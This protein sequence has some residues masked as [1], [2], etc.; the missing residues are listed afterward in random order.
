MLADA[1]EVPTVDDDILKN[2]RCLRDTGEYCKVPK[3]RLTPFVQPLPIPPDADAA[4]RV[5]FLQP[6]VD[7]SDNCK[8][9][10]P[11]ASDPND[12][13]NLYSGEPGANRPPD[14]AL[15]RYAEFRP[16]KRY[17]MFVRP[18]QHLFH[19][20]LMQPSTIWGYG[21]RRGQTF[22]PGPTFRERYGQP[23]VVR[24]HNNL[25]AAYPGNDGF[26]IPQISTHLHNFHSAPESDGGPL[27]FFDTGN[28]MDHHYSLYPAGGDPREVLGQL[29]YHDHRPDFTSQNVYKGLAGNFLA[30]D[31]RDS[32]DERDPHPRA[33][34][35][36]SGEFDMPL[37]V[38]DK[39]FDPISH[40]LVFD[41]FN[42]DGFLG[43]HVT[44]NGAVAPY[45]NV[46]RRKYRFRI[47]NAGPSRIYTFKTCSVGADGTECES[48]EP[49]TALTMIST[50]GNLL[51]HPVLAD[52]FTIGAAERHEFIVDF[53]RFRRGERINLMNIADQ[54]SGKG[55][56]GVFAPMTSV[57][58]QKVLQ[59]RVVGGHVR[60]PSRIPAVM[61][62]KPVISEAEVACE[63]TF[64]FDNQNGGWTING[65]LFDFLP[66]FEVRQGT[67]ERWT[68]VN[69]SRDW[70][71]PIHLYLEE[72][73]I[74]IRDGATP[75][76]LERMR[77]DVTL[78]RPGDSVTVTLRHRDWLK[79]YPMHC[80]NTVHEDHAM[81]LLW[82]VV[83]HA[84]ACI[85]E[86]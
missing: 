65:K 25:P 39:Q 30:Y 34:H 74:E 58:A 86:P 67:A 73:Q 43:E 15:Q 62:Q 83:D 5:A 22:S 55:R 12:G 79:E 36:P 16:V 9:E 45:L 44:V 76:D 75:P 4:V 8:A 47:V 23:I 10:H 40:Q 57:L 21:N 59:F 51:N 49:A 81:M 11:P 1:I 80:H 66:R 28:Y 14:R 54:T 31:R 50:D 46:Q 85:E 37:L 2:F 41:P 82:E 33:F 64:V 52:S 13:C 56:T 35:L 32:N 53:S 6:A 42:L 72:H 70:E 7:P 77:K 69:A 61:R 19:P 71:H 27:M 60:D 68:L 29:W 3:L 48:D 84:V 26:G 24:I 38:A 20:E 18:F 63:R 17:E 78:L